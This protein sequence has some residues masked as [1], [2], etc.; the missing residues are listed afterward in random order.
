MIRLKNRATGGTAAFCA[1]VLTALVLAFSSGPAP[2]GPG[3]DHGHS[4]AQ[5]AP[6]GPAS[7]RFVADSEAYELVGILKSGELVL[8]LDRRSDTAPVTDARIELIVDGESATAEP[9]PDGTYAFRS[10]VLEME[11]EREIIATITHPDATDLLVGKMSISHQALHG[12]HE[13]DDFGHDHAD[14]HAEDGKAVEEALPEPLL[15]ALKNAGISSAD[16]ERKASS[17]PFLA[18]LAMALGILIGAVVRGKTAV[19]L[20]VLGLV[21][22]FGA[23]AA[24]A[25]PGHDHGHAG[26]PAAAN[27]DAPRRLADGAVFLPKP[28]QRLLNLRTRILSPTTARATTRLIGR[29]IADPNRAGLVQSTIDG[30]IKPTDGG[31]PTL[32]RRV[33]EGEILAYVEPAFSPIDAS[34][35][36]QTAG[37]LQQQI[38]LIDARIRRQQRLVDRNVASRANLEDLRIERDG[39]Q[40]RYD[41]LKNARSKPEV[42]RAPVT[43]VIAEV[44]VVA[45][46]VVD[47]AQT[48]FH[49]LDPE[50]LWVE[51]IA[52][53][54]GLA[55]EDTAVTARTAD[56]QSFPLTFVGR[57]RTLQQQAVRL[58]FRIDNPNEALHIGSPVKVLVETGSPIEGLIVPRAAIAQ[59][60]NGQMVTFK[61]LAAERYQPTAIR[62]EQ[63]DVD[64]V[65]IT[66]GLSSGD[67]IVVQGA[68]LVNQIR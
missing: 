33:E 1:A 63:V 41:E 32:G 53:D 66:E 31:L 57:S 61:R 18:G 60:P 16:I 68:P 20:G 19:A 42:L 30:R 10:P 36:R 55:V 47:S 5:T 24:W 8:Y 64:R 65:H 48:L 51:A 23:G 29:V 27:G 3:H 44:R 50:S 52:Y 7:P 12:H 35:V 40:A 39:L 22:V 45:G 46:Q 67:Q 26:A 25:G 34:D 9:R 38:A 6:T 14:H 21:A 58:H 62:F 13:E 15:A 11:G 2:A 4:H 54:P 43:G 17:G 59:A 37:D 28:T 49:V 56:G